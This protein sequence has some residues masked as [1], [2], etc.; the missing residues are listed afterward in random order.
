[1]G[2]TYK[3]IWP[4]QPTIKVAV[5]HRVV[6]G[7]SETPQARHEWSLKDHNIREWCKSNCRASFYFHPGYTREK[8][9]EFEDDVDASMFIL[10]WG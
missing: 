2:I 1:M 3:S 8:F 9:V 5:L 4:D 7:Y 6:Y 10:K